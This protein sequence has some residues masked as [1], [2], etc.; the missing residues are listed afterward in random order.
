MIM[1]RNELS[2]NLTFEE[3]KALAEQEP[4]LKGRWIYMLTRKMMHADEMKHPYP[5][6][7]LSHEEILYFRS[8][9]DAEKYMRNHTPNVYCNCVKQLP[10]GDKGENGYS[11][12]GAEW[13]YGWDG[14]VYGGM[15]IR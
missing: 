13:L 14:K 12:Q 10:F 4:S 3:F 2:S 7:E 5:R 1:I 6:F 11:N 8:L 9:A 15:V